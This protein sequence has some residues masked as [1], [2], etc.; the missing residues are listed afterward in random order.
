MSKLYVQDTCSIAALFKFFLKVSTTLGEVE[1]VP[2]PVF[3]LRLSTGTLQKPDRIHAQG[4]LWLDLGQSGES[5]VCSTKA[6]K[7]L[8]Q[9]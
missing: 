1:V 8:I 2:Y 4:K 6:E 7:A 9:Y 3:A 5:V